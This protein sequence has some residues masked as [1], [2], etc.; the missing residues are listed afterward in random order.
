M[1]IAVWHNLPS[2]GAKRAL[3]NHVRELKVRG[4]Y[5]EAWT[6]DQ[7]SESYLP[8]S[9][10]I[11]EHRKS[12][13]E[14][15]ENIQKNWSPLRR[16]RKI[17]A[18][19]KRHCEE[20]ISE[21]S[22][23]DFDLVFANSCVITYLPFIGQFSK[24]PAVLYLGEPDRRLFE[25]SPSG[26]I[27]ELPRYSKSI[28]GIY[29]YYKDLLRTYSARLLLREESA[30]ARSY[31][32][33]LV[34]SLYSRESVKRA[35]GVDSS[36][37][38]LGVDEG[39]FTIEKDIVKKPFVAGMGR[40]SPAKN[41]EL[42]ISVIALIPEERRP[43]LK[44]ISNKTVHDYLEKINILAKEKNMS[45]IPL[46]DT[47]DAELVKVLNE[48]S[49]MICTSHLE[50]FGLAPLEANMCGTSVVAVAEGGFRES[51]VDGENGFLV[52][53]RGEAEMARLVDLFCS[54]PVY[55]KQMGI[56]AREHALKYWNRKQMADNI[57][58]ELFSMIK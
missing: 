20:C 37:C 33:I 34:N 32:K 22:K 15:L 48:A 16:T 14:E 9:Q 11:T 8:L 35:Y 26:N 13:S 10:L 29:R 6:T 23:G 43:V 57:E 58:K 49:I 25:A 55:A 53:T 28:R 12:I 1:R 3:F 21:I 2:G 39:T 50:P 31:S 7:S 17:T 5:L 30:A 45:F 4:H 36:V 18:L 52:S 38:Y 42:A 51:I 46:S 41:I 56:K 24:I 27:W 54:D 44:W 19:L 40:I 47:P